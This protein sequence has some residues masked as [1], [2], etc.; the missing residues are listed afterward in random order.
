MVAE[1]LKSHGIDLQYEISR[2]QFRENPKGNNL[3]RSS[4]D[5]ILGGFKIENARLYGRDPNTL[6]DV[7]MR[8]KKIN[9]I[10]SHSH[11]AGKKDCIQ[12]DVLGANGAVLAPSLCHP[13]IHLDKCF[14]FYDDKYSDLEITRGDFEETLNLTATAKSRFEMD[15]LLRRSRWL[16]SESIAAGVTHMRAF[17]EVENIVNFNC[18]DAGL[19]LKEEFEEHCNV[20][21]C[22]FGQ[23]PICSSGKK[24]PEGA[25]LIEEALQ[26]EGVDVL[27]TT[28]DAEQ[29][30]IL[31]RSNIEWAVKTALKYKKHLDLHLDYSLDGQKAPLV[32]YVIDTA[33]TMDWANDKT[34]VIC[35][36]SR[37]TLLNSIEWQSIQ[38]Q[39]GDL[40]IFSSVFQLRT[41]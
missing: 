38:K 40:P 34:I 15:D 30:E 23:E 17:V 29:S 28:P 14:L 26:R 21:I 18:L 20:Q 4:E 9:S 5:T 10:C 19:K 3:T 1:F 11:D 41:S 13:H 32:P 39:I 31:A 37:Q 27:G 16:I 33:K 8:A 6:W 12:H 2:V 25:I 22:V 35:N 24:F 36:C 7:S